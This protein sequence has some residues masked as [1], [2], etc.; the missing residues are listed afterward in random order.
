MQQREA[1]CGGAQKAF[2]AG[3][4][5][6]LEA[7]S[8]VYRSENS[9]TSSGVWKLSQ[10]Y[11]GI[12]KAIGADVEKGP[13]GARRVNSTI[14]RWA[15]QY[16]S[17]PSPPIARAMGLMEEAWQI[18][19][20][21]YADKV[22]AEA[23]KPFNDKIEAARDNLEKYK[24]LSSSDPTWY[25]EMLQLA[26]AQSWDGRRF[27][28]LLDEGLDREPLFYS[29]YFAAITYLLPKWSGDID[30]LDD[31]V[32]EAVN[33]T[34]KQEGQAMYARIYWYASQ[35]EFGDDLFAKSRAQWPLMKKGFDD[36][37]VSYPDEWN[38]NNYAKF[39]CMAGDK[40]TTTRLLKQLSSHVVPSAWSDQI[41]Y[42][43]C[44]DW[45][46]GMRSTGR[47]IRRD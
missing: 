30:Q 23:W 14:D 29:T 46:K 20:S 34:S 4:V 36:V 9:R 40:E 19:G 27:D 37:M 31:F 43:N 8:S 7:W 47:V 45:T 32:R 12:A 15:A 38:L 44:L 11:C 10:F 21:T 13:L 28:A 1:I 42:S 26:T 17:S 18:R 22:P 39:A 35:A 3:D 25:G 41:G 16:P 6:A 2:D 5:K 24:A 33:R